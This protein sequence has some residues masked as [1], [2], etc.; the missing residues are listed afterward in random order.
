MW[1]EGERFKYACLV[2]A[3]TESYC[4]QFEITALSYGRGPRIE[5]NMDDSGGDLAP[6]TKAEQESMA[7]FWAMEEANTPKGWGDEQ[8]I[9]YAE[10]SS[11]RMESSQNPGKNLRVIFVVS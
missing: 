9:D 4:L 3:P 8:E 11:K 2:P 7:E 5:A 10:L 1:T 6:P